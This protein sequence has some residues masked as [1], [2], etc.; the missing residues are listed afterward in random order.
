MLPPPNP[1][2]ACSPPLLHPKQPIR[3]RHWQIIDNTFRNIENTHQID[4]N[5]GVTLTKTF[6]GALVLWMINI[7]WAELLRSGV[8]STLH[9][10]AL[11]DLFLEILSTLCCKRES[12]ERKQLDRTSTCCGRHE[13]L[14]SV[15]SLDGRFFWQETT[16][17]LENYDVS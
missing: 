7:F 12:F 5:G 4:I 3:G 16:I 8:H 15:H 9:T 1:G 13:V 2:Y 6:G 17:Y 14:N 11:T 10:V